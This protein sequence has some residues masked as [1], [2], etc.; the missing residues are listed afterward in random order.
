MMSLHDEH[1]E[2]QNLVDKIP[3]YPTLQLISFNSCGIFDYLH[4]S[5]H[6]DLKRQP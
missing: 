4:L 1:I 2:M 3:K 5:Y 6:L